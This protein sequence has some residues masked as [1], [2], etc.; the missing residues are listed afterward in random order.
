M[1]TTCWSKPSSGKGYQRL[2]DAA[3]EGTGTYEVYFNA[4]KCQEMDQEKFLNDAIARGYQVINTDDMQII[5]F[6]LRDIYRAISNPDTHMTNFKKARRYWSQNDSPLY[7]SIIDKFGNNQAVWPS[8]N[9]SSMEQV[10]VSILMVQ[11]MFDNSEN[12]HF[13]IQV[14]K[15]KEAS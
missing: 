9:L 13:H 8:E 10:E 12:H 1:V 11:R 14:R 4:L 7:L 2:G 6:E 3:T 15:R 5:A